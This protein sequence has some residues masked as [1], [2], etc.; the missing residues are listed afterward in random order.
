MFIWFSLGFSLTILGYHQFASWP[1]WTVILPVVVLV[2]FVLNQKSY[3]IGNFFIGVVLAWC[4]A[5]LHLVS[6]PQLSSAAFDETVWAEGRLIGLI[7]QRTRASDQT[8][9]LRF[10]MRLDEV[11]ALDKSWRQAWWWRKPKIRLSCYDCA[12]GFAKPGEVWRM[13]VRLKPIHGSMNPGGW[14]YEAWAYQNGLQATGY[15]RSKEGEPLKRDS[16]WSYHTWRSD[17][18]A[19]LN[20]LWSDSEFFGIYN[21]LMVADR[22]AITDLQWQV[23]RDTGTIHLMAISGLHMALVALMGFG[24]GRVIWRLSLP[25]TQYWP[26]DW[27][28]AGLAVLL[29]TLY[30][31]LAGWTVPTQR[32]WIMVVVGVVFLFMRRRFQPWSGLFLAAFLVLVWHPPSIL[33][34]GFWLSFLAVGLIFLVLSHPVLS[35]WKGWRSLLLVQGVLTLGLLPGLWFY[36]QEVPLYSALANLLAVPLV[37]F[38]ALPLLFITAFVSLLSL[39]WAGYLVWLSDQVWSALWWTLAGIANWPYQQIELGRVELWQVVVIYLALFLFGLRSEAWV[40]Y[41]AVGLVLLVLLSL[42]PVESVKPGDFWMTLLDVG[43]GLAV[44]IETENHRLVYD[45]GPR[46]NEQLDGASLAILPYLRTRGIRYVDKLIVSHADLDHAGGASR[47]LAEIAVG[48][49]LTGEVERL[50]LAGFESCEAGQAWWWD[51]VKFEI[52]APTGDEMRSS[53]DWSCVLRVSSADSALLLTGDLSDKYEQKLLAEYPK[54]RL[55]ASILVAGHHGSRF[56]TDSVF[57]EEVDP[58][59]VLFSAGH[60]NRFGF[61]HRDVIERVEAQGVNHLNTACEGAIQVRF[62]SAELNIQP[63]YRHQI[64]RAFH[65]VCD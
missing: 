63:G 47:L 30:G 27:V 4:V 26:R 9:V 54:D 36:Y 7:E 6:S 17:W 55:S 44:V 53:N 61:P 65:R 45:T 11:F 38:V 24:L 13:P 33:A 58:E 60:R 23:M 41:S 51:G 43:Q 46:F 3:R 57:L 12:D 20:R 31:F 14:D 62:G 56:S 25:W 5:V 16:G 49:R 39:E 1:K 15:V 52:L 50:N 28:G 37:S 42:K 22:Q 18:V 59:W 29:T 48:E 10:E 35:G 21:A 19:H 2:W 40:R 64:K 8:L 32:A 34:P